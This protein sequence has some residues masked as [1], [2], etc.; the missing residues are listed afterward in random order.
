MTKKAATS[1]SSERI[2]PRKALRGKYRT[3]VVSDR[4]GQNASLIEQ[5]RN[6]PER[7]SAMFG[8]LADCEDVRV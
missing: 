8:A 5:R 2:A 6:K 7:L 1:A 3:A 4:G